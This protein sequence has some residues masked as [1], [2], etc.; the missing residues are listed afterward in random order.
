METLNLTRLP[1][2][3]L[4]TTETEKKMQPLQKFKWRRI[5]AGIGLPLG[6]G[7]FA[8][9]N[10]LQVLT[11][12]EIGAAQ[13]NSLEYLKA[14]SNSHEVVG[15]YAISELFSIL[16]Y[17][18]A[19]LGLVSLIRGRGATV[20]YMGAIIG[21]LGCAGHGMNILLKQVE[22][23]L[24]AP[25]TDSR[26][27]ATI[28]DNILTQGGAYWLVFFCIILSLPVIVGGLVRAG[29]APKWTFIVFL[30]VPVSAFL[31]PFGDVGMLATMW[32]MTS[33]L[34]LC[35]WNFIKAGTLNP[36]KVVR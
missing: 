9:E 6:A 1:D 35:G 10:T 12:P 17:I 20:T 8:L 7:L 26:Q 5:L 18:L 11:A 25:G 29:I 3:I 23:V 21:L 28:Y 2:N 13:G 36:K 31:N 34:A 4:D 27:M 15:F 30:L 14:V 24:S 19:F 33:I 22:I 16:A 32:A